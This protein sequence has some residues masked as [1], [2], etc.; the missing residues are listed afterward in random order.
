MACQ[1]V[2]RELDKLW[3]WIRIT[4]RE[5]LGVDMAADLLHSNLVPSC[6]RGLSECCRLYCGLDGIASL[7]TRPPRGLRRNTQE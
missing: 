7:R 6:L 5:K 1:V 3:V 2:S 4:L